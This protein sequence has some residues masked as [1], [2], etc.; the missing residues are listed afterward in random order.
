MNTRSKQLIAW[1]CRNKYCT[2][3]LVFNDEF[4]FALH[5]NSCGEMLSG[6][7]C[8][9][10]SVNVYLRVPVKQHKLS[11]S[12]NLSEVKGVRM[13]VVNYWFGKAP[14]KKLPFTS[15]ICPE[16]EASILHDSHIYARV[17]RHLLQTCCCQTNIQQF[18]P[19]SRRS[20]FLH[21]CPHTLSCLTWII[22]IEKTEE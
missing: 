4:I 14:I 9:T 15:T 18:L 2:W 3:V 1:W 22:K 16:S 17:D 12:I 13:L 21:F 11:I 10:H 20:L 5:R 7:F 8:E 6:M 19:L